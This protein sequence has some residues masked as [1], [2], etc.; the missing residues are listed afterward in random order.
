MG[1][2]SRGIGHLFKGYAQ[3]AGIRA[4]GDFCFKVIIALCIGWQLWDFALV[5][6]PELN[7]RREYRT[8]LDKV[9]LEVLFLEKETAR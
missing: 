6:I 1:K 3:G 7:A 9:E 4:W 2:I 5:P 8:I